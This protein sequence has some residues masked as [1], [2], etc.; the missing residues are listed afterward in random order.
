MQP[1]YLNR[2]TIGQCEV[3]LRRLP[4]RS[5]PL[6]LFSPPYNLG[7]TSGGGFPAARMGHYSERAPLGRARGGAGKW[8]GGALAQG[9]AD[10]TDDALPMYRYR[11]WLMDVLRQCWRVLSDDGAIF[12][13]HKPRILNGRLLAPMDYLPPA[14]R[15]FVR[16]EIIWARAGGM[17]FSP[18]FYVPTHER[19]VVIARPGWRLKSKGAS[20]AGD[21]WYIPQQSDTWHPAPFPRALAERV[22]ETTGARL[23]CDPFMGSGTTAKAARKL[24][25][26]WIGIERSPIYAARAE[27]EIAAVEPMHPAMR[28][29]LA[30]TDMWSEAA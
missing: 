28:E 1:D 13:N 9:Y 30:Q 16:Q 11:G 7:T 18:A 24:G 2:I 3:V 27:R 4:D 15:P 29:V 25:V 23:V 14:L 21:V 26:A 19:I 10:S 17:N 20:G 6:F 8:G 5:V 12:F 22:L